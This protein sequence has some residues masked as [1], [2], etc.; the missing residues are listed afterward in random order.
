MLLFGHFLTKTALKGFD[1][2]GFYGICIC[3][4]GLAQ[5]NTAGLMCVSYRGELP[6]AGVSDLQYRALQREAD[7][8]RCRHVCC[9]ICEIC[10]PDTVTDMLPL[11][12]RSLTLS[13]D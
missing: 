4:F 2:S 7:R 12:E 1:C 13:P 6:C 3:R 11:E 5:F 9:E 8:Q 10:E